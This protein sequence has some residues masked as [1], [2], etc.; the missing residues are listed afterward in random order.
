[1][2]R[3]SM[4]GAGAIALAAAATVGACNI[5][6]DY[7]HPETATPAGWREGDPAQGAQ[8]PAPDWWQ[9]FGSTEL[10]ALMAEAQRANA[11][12]GAAA[13]RVKEADAQ[14]R[15]AGAPLLPLIEATGGPATQQVTS[16]F[17]PNRQIHYST[18]T[19]AVSASYEIDFWG[20]NAAALAAAKATA[21]A[22]RYDEEVVTLSVIS[23]VATT[24]FQAL[25]LQD[26][27]QVARDNLANA[28]DVLAI[29]NGRRRVGTAADLELAQQETVVAGLRAAIPPLEQQLAQMLDA[30]AIL[31]VKPPDEMKLAARSLTPLS[32]PSVAPGLP[33]ELLARR[34]DVREAEAQLVSANANIKVAR[35]QFFPSVS[36][37]AEGGFQ[38]LAV[39]SFLSLGTGIYSL[40][41]SV[42]QPIFEGGRLKGQLAFSQAQY[43]E[44]L[45]NYRKAVVSAFSNVEDALAATRRTA[46]QQAAEELAVAQARQ[47]YKIAQAQYRVGSVDLLTVLNTENALFSAD[48]LLAQDRIAHM[49]ALVSLFNALGGGW[50][51]EPSAAPATASLPTRD[52]HQ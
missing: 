32:A 15:I 28:G 37:T 52:D 16:P 29:I 45:W 14:T 25:G 24:Y 47:A 27:L 8:W 7:R 3:H 6:P 46:E 40:A 30:L 41:A 21:V 36:L 18:Y 39:S 17:S 10:N 49:Q 22:S 19:A 13:A 43:E 38:S 12:L 5:G 20:K 35:A 26:R 4:R 23:S 34:P 51:D 31:L 42:T 2:S 11:D 1:M 50:K 33:S 9:E 48:D 44:L